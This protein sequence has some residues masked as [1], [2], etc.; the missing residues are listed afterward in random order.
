[1]EH[2]QNVLGQAVSA[3]SALPVATSRF[4]LIELLV[5]ITIIMILTGMVLPALSMARGKAREIAC[6]SQL[7]QVGQS[8][9]YYLEDFQMYPPGIN[10]TETFANALRDH[11]YPLVEP[12][13]QIFDCP[14]SDQSH[15]EHNLTYGSHPVVIPDLSTGKKPFEVG[16]IKRPSDVF[17]Y[18]ESC[19]MVNGHCRGVVDQ[20]EG[21][22]DNG[23]P[24]ERENSLTGDFEDHNVDGVDANA[25]WLRWRHHKGRSGNAAYFD[26]HAATSRFGSLVEKNVKVNY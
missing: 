15:P 8:T 3:P 10:G 22:M 26:G 13:S 18:I 11:I 19:Q 17:M 2:G 9:I 1:M 20:I 6:M 23:D 25:G 16:I 12:P 7:K 4:T 5:V 24:D 14:D 21:I